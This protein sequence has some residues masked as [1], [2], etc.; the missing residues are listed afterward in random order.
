M[1][2]AVC[3]IMLHH[4]RLGPFISTSKCALQRVIGLV[5]S[6]WSPLGLLV[7]IPLAPQ[8]ADS[9]G[10]DENRVA[11]SRVKEVIGFRGTLE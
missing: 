3:P 2:A 1:E 9:N 5:Q 11:R 7:D 4:I 6:S 10:C 8:L